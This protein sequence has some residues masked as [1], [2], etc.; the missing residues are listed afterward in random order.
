MSHMGNS[1]LSDMVSLDLD[2]LPATD[3]AGLPEHLEVAVWT[4]I[5]DAVQCSLL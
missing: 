5:F 1:Q 4:A 3:A 2:A